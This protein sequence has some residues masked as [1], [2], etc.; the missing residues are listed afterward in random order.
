MRVNFSGPLSQTIIHSIKTASTEYPYIMP[1]SQ[2]P[3]TGYTRHMIDQDKIQRIAEETAKAALGA[4]CVSWVSSAPMIDFRGDEALRVTI[5]LTPGSAETLSD[6]QLVDV[7]VRVHDALQIAGEDRYPFIGFE[8]EDELQAT[9][10]GQEMNK[11]ADKAE[12]Q[13]ALDVFGSDLP[14]AAFEGVFDPPRQRNWRE[15]DL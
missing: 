12:A 8:S 14:D 11:I 15:V 13:T 4:R 7:T 3:E 9:S 5:V 2:H 1:L 6:R 10:N